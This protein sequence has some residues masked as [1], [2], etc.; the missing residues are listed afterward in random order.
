MDVTENASDIS[1]RN[2]DHIGI[3]V[4]SINSALSLYHGLFGLEV[5]GIEEVEIENVR[6]ATLDAGETNIELMEP[7][8]EEGPIEKFLSK[9]GPGIHHICFEVED[10]S[11]IMEI[12]R[13]S[14][15]EPVYD[16]SRAGAN[17]AQINFLHPNDTFGVLLE[18]REK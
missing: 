6:T 12:F 3:A 9:H 16:E 15:Y 11:S 18:L 13:Q 17:N 1:V 4:D 5:E 10:I 2:I 7:L 14:G 8:E